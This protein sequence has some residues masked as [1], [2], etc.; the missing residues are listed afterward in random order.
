MAGQDQMGMGGD[1]K[2]SI[3]LVT[4]NTLAEKNG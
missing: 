3:N 4:A 2:R 1:E